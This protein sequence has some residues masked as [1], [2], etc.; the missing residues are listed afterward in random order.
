MKVKDT[1]APGKPKSIRLRNDHEELAKLLNASS[2]PNGEILEALESHFGLR[3]ASV[4][5]DP[6]V[7]RIVEEV[8][9][10]LEKL[11]DQKIKLALAS[12]PV[13]PVAV[14][15]G[16]PTAAPAVKEFSKSSGA[17][18][19]P[20][21]ANVLLAKPEEDPDISLNELEGFFDL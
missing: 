12:V 2:N 20:Q 19:P 1:W 9:G 13:N 18:S 6:V 3:P 4:V 7:D 8:C 14:N 5:S 21:A 17:Q 10:Q 15:H 11:F 16:V